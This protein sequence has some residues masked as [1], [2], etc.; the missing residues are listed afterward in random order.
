MCVGPFRLGIVDVP[1]HERFVRNMLAGATGMHLAMLVVAADDSIKPQTREHLDIL[2]LLDLRAGV[3]AITKCDLAELEWIELVEEEIRE[4]VT[5]SFLE[6]AAI[7]RTS[8]PS[9]MGIESLREELQRAAQRAVQMQLHDS[10][11][12]PFRMAI[13]RAFTIA[14]HGTVVT[15]SV[16]SGRVQL[17]DELEIEPGDFRVR[18]RGLQN[19]DRTATQVQRG[20]RA[21]INLAGIHHGTIGRGHELATPTHLRPSRLLA[22]RIRAVASLPRPIKNRSRV[23]VHV[24]TAE[25]LA[26]LVLLETDQVAAGEAAFCQ[27]FLAAEAVTTWNQPF[28]LRSESP[29]QTIGGGHVL[30]P[31]STRLPRR[32]ADTLQKLSDLTSSDSLP[33]AAAAL[34]LRRLASLAE[35]RSDPYGGH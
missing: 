14:G 7:V 6:D 21:A 2:R 8:A 33:R 3:I 15:G 16:S 32:D 31:Q 19:H 17:G 4:L 1:G 10:R 12:G 25:L 18:V 9:G 5:G 13:D 11:G 35:R 27:L 29:M 28:V 20:Q 24:G 22:A 26:T 30:V 34:Y 23:R